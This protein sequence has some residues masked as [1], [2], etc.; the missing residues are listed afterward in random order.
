ME[1][2]WYAFK[3]INL[4]KLFYFHENIKRSLHFKCH[5][6][7]SY[8][9]GMQ[10]MNLALRDTLKNFMNSVDFTDLLKNRWIHH[11]K[12][13]DTANGIQIEEKELDNV[14]K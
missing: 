11:R 7:L 14:L 8:L 1:I 3:N 5:A 9:I 12:I 13:A 10:D 2:V 6:I 4:P